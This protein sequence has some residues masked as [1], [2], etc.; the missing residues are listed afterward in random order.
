MQPGTNLKRR[1]VT[2]S[3]ALEVSV[4]VRGR[5]MTSGWLVKAVKSDTTNLVNT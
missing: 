1:L 2:S 5:F 4:W 3:Y